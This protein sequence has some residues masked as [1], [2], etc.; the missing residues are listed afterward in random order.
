MSNARQ[1]CPSSVW[2]DSVFHNEM[3]A[4]EAHVDA[5]PEQREVSAVT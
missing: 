2:T 1:S 4:I 3:A 5:V